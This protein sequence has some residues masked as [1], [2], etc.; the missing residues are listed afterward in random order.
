[1][2]PELPTSANNLFANIESLQPSFPI[3][4]SV[5]WNS[6]CNLSIQILP[7]LCKKPL[8]GNDKGSRRAYKTL[9]MFPVRIKNAS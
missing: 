5:G 2:T 4:I 3:V 7:L 1:M 9:H 6:I 8:L